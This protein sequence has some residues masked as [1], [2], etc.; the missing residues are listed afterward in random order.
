GG[1][2]KPEQESDLTSMESSARSASPPRRNGSVT[3]FESPV[4]HE[5]SIRTITQA[6]GATRSPSV[7]VRQKHKAEPVAS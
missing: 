3:N 6:A 2:K 5:N 1:D 7:P 4:R